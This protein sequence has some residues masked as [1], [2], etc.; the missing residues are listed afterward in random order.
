MVQCNVIADYCIRA[1]FQTRQ[2]C[3][4]EFVTTWPPWNRAVKSYYTD[5]WKMCLICVCVCLSL[6]NQRYLG[7]ARFNPC[8]FGA[9]FYLSGRL[10]PSNP[11][12]GALWVLLIHDCADDSM[13]G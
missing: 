12:L 6:K 11:R 7:S 5:I 3:G 8:F 10:N 1:G 2:Q 9:A 4:P 13:D